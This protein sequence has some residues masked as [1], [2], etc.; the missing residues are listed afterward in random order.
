MNRGIFLI[1]TAALLSLGACSKG[2]DKQA[3]GTNQS[4]AEV[5][6]EVAEVKIQP[7]Q[8]QAT[9]ETIDVKLEN[10]PE[11]MPAGMME[12]MKGRKTT[13]TYCITPEQAEKSAGDFLAGQ[14]DA[15]CTYQG[16][17]MGG[18]KVSGTMSC[19]GPDGKGQ[20]TMKMSGSYSPTSYDTTVEM[21]TA[22]MG[23]GVKMR[24]KS[25]GS[26]KRI[27]ECP[28]EKAKS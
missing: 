20:M 9:Q 16:F 3:S 7:G 19:A 25:H 11:G 18:G 10:A 1:G 12:S 27:G 8:W 4:V 23:E 21:E 22:G 24:I 14:K 26:G 28:A 2:D 5:A 13:I 6:K 15:K 17:Q